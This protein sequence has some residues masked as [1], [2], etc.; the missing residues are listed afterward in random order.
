MFTYRLVTDENDW[1][2][3]IEDGDDAAPFRARE[4][5]EDVQ[6]LSYDDWNPD[7]YGGCEMIRGVR[8]DGTPT[9]TG[10]VKCGTPLV[11]R[12][13]QIPEPPTK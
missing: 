13:T 7:L 8:G 3:V 12:V 5:G 9:T 1:K 2:K 11:M 6:F 10:Y 4:T